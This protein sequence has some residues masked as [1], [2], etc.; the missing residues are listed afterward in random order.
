MPSS[1]RA[2]HF[3]LLLEAGRLLSSKLDLQD[4]LTTVMQLAAKVVDAETASLLLVDLNTDELYF[5]VAL[6]L[7]PELA[8]IRLKMGEGI[9]G[10][11]AASGQPLIINDVHK[12][13]RWSS[14]VDQDS[15]FATRSILAT[16]IL[17]K[18][19]CIGVVEAI[20]RNAGDFSAEDLRI[21]EAFASQAGVAIE[22]ARLFASLQEERAKLST[23]FNEMRDAALLADGLRT[24][25]VQ[26]EPLPEG[27]THSLLEQ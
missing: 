15:G 23:V 14:K 12:D 3:E 4:L 21:F 2:E 19:R 6:G 8:D 20:N 25:L 26:A 18:G 1:R 16:P 10:A 27:G 22:N 13:P 5:H 24:A 11:V 7:P 9:C 17:V